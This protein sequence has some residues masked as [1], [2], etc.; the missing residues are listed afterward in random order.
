M[1]GSNGLT[2]PF[3]RIDRQRAGG[4]R[5]AEHPL[6]HEQRVEGD[7]GRGLGAVDQ[8]EAFLGAKLERLHAELLERVA[9]GEDFAG[10]VDPPL[11]HHR[12]D[13][14]GERGEVARCADAALRRD[15]RHGV[16]VEQAW[17]ASITSGRTP[18]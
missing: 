17:S 8:G 14:V 1:R 11:A 16:L 15:Q 12:G 5:G 3:K 18:E 13:E 9:G 7:G 10:E 4:E 6:G 2:L